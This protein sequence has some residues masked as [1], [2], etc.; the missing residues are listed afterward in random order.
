MYLFTFTAILASAVTTAS[1]AGCYSE[2]GP[3]WGDLRQ[4]ANNAADAVCN[5]NSGGVAGNFDGNSKYACR[6]LGET[7][8]AECTQSP[9]PL[10]VMYAPVAW[11]SVIDRSDVSLGHGNRISQRPGLQVWSQ[12]GDQWLWLGW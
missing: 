4:A 10:G 7:M 8:K 5:G 1:A 12:G 11:T 6:N 3:G 2:T 9:P